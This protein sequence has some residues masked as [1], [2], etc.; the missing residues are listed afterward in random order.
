[1]TLTND[2][3][4][5]LSQ[6]EKW[7]RKY[8]HQYIEISGVLGTGPFELIQAFIEAEQFDPREIMYLSFDQK[9]VVELASKQLHSYY[10]NGIIYK[11][12]RIVNFNSLSVINN[13]ST[14]ME[15]QWKKEVRKKI[16]SKYK[17]IIVFDSLLMN[18]HLIADLSTFGLPIICI[19]D[20]MLLPSPDSYN[21]MRDPNIELREPHPDLL[22]DP[23]NYFAYKA[24][25]REVFKAGNYDTVSVI[26]RKQM[27]LYNLKSVDMVI[28]LNDEIRDSTN[29]IYRRKILNKQNT[30]TSVGEKL[31][32][33]DNLYAH[34]LVNQDEKR[35]KVY[36]TKGLVGHISKIYKHQESTRYVY[37]EFTPDFYL[38]TFTDLMLDRFELNHID[39]V[40]RQSTPDEIFRAE[41]AYALTPQLARV[42][43][44]DKLTLI[45]AYDDCDDELYARLLYTGIT[46]ARKTLNIVI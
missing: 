2:Q 4:V 35:I 25:I 24:S 45:S 16:D 26:P 39:L 17:L 37:T 9:Q 12:N 32:V 15:Y 29:N 13:R 5:G 31:I 44:W 19:R 18:E 8:Q 3:Y 42:N 41:Y 1:M 23:I 36:L 38:D 7:Y 20:P 21:Y 43:H 22:R 34:K 30:I 6:L 11:Y 10:I 14:G 28:A 27:N 33:M 46:R 40:S